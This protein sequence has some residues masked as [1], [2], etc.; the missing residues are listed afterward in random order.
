MPILCK[1]L[2]MNVI[3]DIGHW[4]QYEAPAELSELMLGW[5]KTRFPNP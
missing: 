1:D 3:E 4:T 2:D 5:L